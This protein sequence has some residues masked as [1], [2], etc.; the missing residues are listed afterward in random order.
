MADLSGRK[1]STARLLSGF[2]HG[3]S[4]YNQDNRTGK[5]ISLRFIHLVKYISEKFFLCNER[6]LDTVKGRRAPDLRGEGKDLA[7]QMGY[8]WA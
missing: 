5:G 4:Q 2:F 1:I 7:E 6:R 8:Y 3:I